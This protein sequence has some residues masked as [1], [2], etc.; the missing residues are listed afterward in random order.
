[1][2]LSRS[3]LLSV[4]VPPIAASFA[5]LILGAVGRSVWVTHLLAIC[6]AGA[7]AVV[8]NRLIRVTHA[9]T[10]TLAI[11]LATVAGITI[12]LLL[13]G[14]VGP[15]RWAAIGPLNLYM[16]PLLLP[17]F[18]AACS[19]YVRERNRY[20]LVAFAATIVV[21]ALLAAQ[22]D[23]SQVL[24]LL[25]GSAVAFARYRANALKSTVTLAIA[26]LIAAWAFKQPDPLEPVSYVEHVFALA[27]WYSVLSGV[28]VVACAVTFVVGLLV[29]SFSGP[30]WLSAVAAYYAVLFICS[31]AG[32]TPAPLIGY[33]AGPIL[34]FGLMVAVSR[35][36]EAE[37]CAVNPLVRA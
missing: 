28:A 9:R 5:V 37:A 11:I 18:L 13:R 20:D 34:G 4:A 35:G 30:A 22:P 27:F 16:A 10:V 14:S 31:V 26:A 36:I 1:M 25:V 19:V 6:L 24:A 12:P 3:C 29:C 15:N 17:A 8:G 2:N 23:A 7:V 21:S 32:L 33:G